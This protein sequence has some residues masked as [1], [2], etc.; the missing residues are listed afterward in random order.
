MQRW[1]RWGIIALA[2]I[3]AAKPNSGE[4]GSAHIRTPIAQLSGNWT[5]QGQARF[6]Q[7]KSEDLACRA[8]YTVKSEGAG[9]GLAIRCAS[10]SYRIEMRAMLMFDGNRITGIWEERTFNASGTVAG[11]AGERDIDLA[12]AGSAVGSMTVKVEPTG[13]RV[14]FNSA[15]GDFNG[16]S[17]RFNRS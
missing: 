14:E 1:S 12:I 2:S 16:V 10:A 17:I 6:A 13:H 9:M 11:I 5:G 15:G 7:G 4:A 8:Y 3:I